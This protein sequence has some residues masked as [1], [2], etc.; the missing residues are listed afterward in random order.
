MVLGRTKTPAGSVN[1]P[2]LR[3]P[4]RTEVLQLQT[5]IQSSEIKIVTEQ[6]PVQRDSPLAHK[7]PLFYFYTG[8]R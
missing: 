4:N 6:H 7:H 8:G 5:V 2:D 1:D 3:R